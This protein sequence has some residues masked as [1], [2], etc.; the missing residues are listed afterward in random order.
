[1][2]LKSFAKINWSLRI[3]GRR[4]DGFHEVNTVLQTIS[5]HDDL[6]FEC[7]E[8]SQV[9]LHS[10]STNI[11]RDHTNLIVKAAYALSEFAGVRL[12]VDVH[13]DKRIPPQGG[14]G[15]ASSNAAVTLLAL[16]HLWETDL[17][18]DQLESIGTRLGSD[19]S[20]FFTGGTARATGT[21]S[22]ISALEDTIK[23]Y[24]LIVTPNARISTPAAYSSL[25]A[26]SLTTTGSTSILSSSFAGPISSDSDQWALTN[27]FEGVIFEIEPE[28][29]RAQAALFEAGAQ[30]GL[31]A[32]SGSSVFGIF[33]RK[34]ARE[35]ALADLKLEEGWQVFSCETISRAEYL[36]SLKS[37]GFPQLRSLKFQTD[38]GA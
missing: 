16:N 35:R 3:L 24:L 33:E 20:F 15:G 29:K 28:I 1:M 36:E 32:G 7:R 19:V 26:A 23:R 17:N 12:G 34:E 10:D 4:T 21:G 2:Q 22:T 25:K 9:I 14:L 6:T 31:L 18:C 37:T 13:V 11:P 5:L 38:T 30:G 8:D 27:D